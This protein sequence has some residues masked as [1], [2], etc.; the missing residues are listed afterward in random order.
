MQRVKQPWDELDWIG[1]GVGREALCRRSGNSLH[2]FVRAHLALEIPGVP[3]LANK[4]TEALNKLRLA[5]A[6][7]GVKEEE[8]ADGADAHDALE[9]GVDRVG[10]LEVVE[11]NCAGK[12]G[13]AIKATGPAGGGVKG[14][15]LEREEAG[16]ES[17]AD[18]IKRGVKHL[19]AVR[20]AEDTAS[21]EVHEDMVEG[22]K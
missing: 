6:V 15:D 19:V 1:L 3:D 5:L 12:E 13:G 7:V 20:E 11:A 4:L 21:A 17:G 9:N 22:L 14:A 16:V 18:V 10:A 8:V 2:E